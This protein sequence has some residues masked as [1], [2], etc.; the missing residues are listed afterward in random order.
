MVFYNNSF[1]VSCSSEQFYDR[2]FDALP[3]YLENNPYFDH[4]QIIES[5]PTYRKCRIKKKNIFDFVPT[6]F[7]NFASIQMFFKNI[8]VNHYNHDL[9][10]IEW[11]VQNE[12]IADLYLLHGKTTVRSAG[13][14][15]CIVSLELH[16]EFSKEHRNYFLRWIEDRVPRII[17]NEIK[18]LYT[19][20]AHDSMRS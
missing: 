6:M 2:M 19:Q 11:Q 20:F 17:F 7:Q 9:K 14:T 5:G 15:G 8:E 12:Q 18:I 3:S 10:T 1:L 4:Y 13:G 16:F